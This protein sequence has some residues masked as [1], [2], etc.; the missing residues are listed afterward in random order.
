MFE[1]STELLL[2]FHR[3]RVAY[4]RPV[5]T[6]YTGHTATCPFRRL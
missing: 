5:D 2:L 6:V 1:I 3:R 4:T